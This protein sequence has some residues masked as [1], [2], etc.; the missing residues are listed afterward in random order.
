MFQVQQVQ[1]L[2][3][4]HHHLLLQS[5]HLWT[6]GILLPLEIL[7]D[8][9]PRKLQMHLLQEVRMQG[10][11]LHPI[12]LGWQLQGELLEHS[13]S[14]FWLQLLSFVFNNLLHK[15]NKTQYLH[16]YG[17]ILHLDFSTSTW[18]LKGKCVHASNLCLATCQIGQ[19]KSLSYG[20][21]SCSYGR[22]LEERGERGLMMYFF[23]VVLV[24]NITYT[25]VI[26]A[27]TKDGGKWGHYEGTNFVKGFPNFLFNCIMKIFR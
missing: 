1:K 23:C 5:H 8:L 4:L 7:V 6:L 12:L 18:L 11:P 15:C 20:W 25:I 14:S 27:P 10:P 13:H 21:R 16:F 22:G 24:C 9:E 3:L 26:Q 19:G 2:P 17:H